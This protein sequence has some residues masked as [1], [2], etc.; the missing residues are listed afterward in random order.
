MLDS[1]E[2]LMGKVRDCSEGVGSCRKKLQ[3]L[4]TAPVAT[5]VQMILMEATRTYDLLS[6]AVLVSCMV[7]QRNVS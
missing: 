4:G 7:P 3:L 5:D 1:Q 2:A 6:Y